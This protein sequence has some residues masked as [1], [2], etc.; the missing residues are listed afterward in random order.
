M[1]V[2]HYI[3]HNL[4]GPCDMLA[5][6]VRQYIVDAMK[7]RP[8]SGSVSRF[9][10]AYGQ[11]IVIRACGLVSSLKSV[12]AFLS[13]K[14]DYWDWVWDEGLFPDKVVRAFSSYTFDITQSRRGAL[15]GPNSDP[16]HDNKSGNLSHL[17]KSS[18]GSQGIKSYKGR[19]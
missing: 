6:G 10:T 2:R 17:S 9:V 5:Y 8:V 18:R 14:S 7:G 19:K 3:L 1:L 12:E 15:R 4:K 16:K 11:S 13:S